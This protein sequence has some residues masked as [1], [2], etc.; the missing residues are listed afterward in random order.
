MNENK[1]EMVVLF[2]NGEWSTNI[3]TPVGLCA[4]IDG[5]LD[6]IKKASGQKISRNAFIL[7]AIKFFFD[8]LLTSKSLEEVIKK[9]DDVKIR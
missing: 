7:K 1:S 9:M 2:P 6:Q 3:R 8:Y 5:M 4:K